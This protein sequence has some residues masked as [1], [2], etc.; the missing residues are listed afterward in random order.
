MDRI[1]LCLPILDLFTIGIKT[2]LLSAVSLF[3]ES[4]V[5]QMSKL[6][7]TVSPIWHLVELVDF[8]M[9]ICSGKERFQSSTLLSGL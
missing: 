4:S 7:I 8:E 5:T 6:K 1:G 2:L 3:P 9:G